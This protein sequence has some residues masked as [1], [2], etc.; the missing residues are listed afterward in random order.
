MYPETIGKEPVVVCLLLQAKD[1]GDWK[2]WNR[3]L[4]MEKRLGK[5]EAEKEVGGGAFLLDFPLIL[6]GGRPKRKGKMKQGEE[7]N[8]WRMTRLKI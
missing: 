4:L 3:W 2:L 1:N 7:G 8:L 6:L 5:C